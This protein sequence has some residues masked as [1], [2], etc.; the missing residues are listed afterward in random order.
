MR[1]VPGEAAVSA[2]SRPVLDALGPSWTIG[3]GPPLRPTAGMRS[4][5]GTR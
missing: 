1:Q 5:A 4:A 3:R 2:V